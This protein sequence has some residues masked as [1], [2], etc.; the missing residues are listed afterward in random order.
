MNEFQA[1]RS[2][3]CNGV[4]WFYLRLTP[5]RGVAMTLVLVIREGLWLA[6]CLYTTAV[7][8]KRF[9][10]TL[11]RTFVRINDDL[12]VGFPQ[13]PGIVGGSSR[14]VACIVS[15]CASNGSPFFHS[16]SATAAILRASVTFASSRS[17][18]RRTEAS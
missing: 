9:A 8:R 5:V 18:P 3:T 11:S 7:G 16:R 6:E 12:R 2:I 4:A 15:F 13:S 1:T 17:T 14:Y 10:E